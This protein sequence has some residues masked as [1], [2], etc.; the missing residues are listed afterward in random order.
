METIGGTPTYVTL[1]SG[2]Y[3]TSHPLNYGFTRSFRIVD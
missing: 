2:E 1:P 3:S